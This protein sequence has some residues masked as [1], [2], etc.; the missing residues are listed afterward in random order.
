MVFGVPLFFITSLLA[1]ANELVSAATMGAV[2]CD[3]VVQPRRV[4]V[5]SRTDRN[6]L[7]VIDR[8]ALVVSLLLSVALLLCTGF[9]FH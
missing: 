6:I 8:Q 7:S 1:F 9:T 5:E 3:Q 2:L 4:S